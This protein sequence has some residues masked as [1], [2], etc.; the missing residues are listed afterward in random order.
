MAD[1]PRFDPALYRLETFAWCQVEYLFARE[2]TRRNKDMPWQQ[3]YEEALA[4]VDA[5]QA[6]DAPLTVDSTQP[7]DLVFWPDLVCAANAYASQGPAHREYLRQSF[8][9]GGSV[10]AMPTA[11]AG[12]CDR[13]VLDDPE[14]LPAPPC[15][16]E[17]VAN[18][19]WIAA[20]AST[21]MV[22]AVLGIRLVSSVRR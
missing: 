13:T 6:G 21:L 17:H 20:G 7:R 5:I 15:V 9:A 1:L 3:A 4:V 16:P 19:A 10:V 2:L 22:L 11:M 14:Y 12:G 18:T 8:A